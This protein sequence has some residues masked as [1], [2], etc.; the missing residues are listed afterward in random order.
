[1]SYNTGM[2]RA[3]TNY[4]KIKNFDEPFYA[5]EF[6][7]C[8][9]DINGMVYNGLIEATG[10]TKSYEIEIEI[11]DWVSQTAVKKTIP[12]MV[13][14]WKAVPDADAKCLRRLF[15]FPFHF[16]CVKNDVEWMREFVAFYDEH[17][18]LF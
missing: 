18:E 9:G 14:E 10:N 16:N 8:G 17:P 15:Q 12:T 11:W 13:K 1:M 6:G 2:E 7:F 3:I 4:Q 5:S